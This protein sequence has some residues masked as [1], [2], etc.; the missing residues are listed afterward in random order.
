M[1]TQDIF[2]A[3]LAFDEAAAVAKTQAEI[4][5]GTDIQTI[6]NDG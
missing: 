6:L 5:A 2:D 4:D 1:T 3:V